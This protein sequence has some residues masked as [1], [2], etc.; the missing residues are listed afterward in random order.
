MVMLERAKVKL[1]AEMEGN[2]N[3]P[4]VQVVGGFLLQ[5]IESN[6]AV[7]E[8]ILSADKTI[9]KSLDEMKR[10]AEKKKVGNCAV[11]TDQEGFDV[12]LKYF[13]ISGTAPASVVTLTL[14]A[15]TA[16][17]SPIPVPKPAAEFDINLEELL[18]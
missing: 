10:A 16:S 11:L 7:V 12:V 8:K 15:S 1:K 5:Y 17:T 6:P 14:S 3:N 9:L 13:G 2:K 18:R 4:Y